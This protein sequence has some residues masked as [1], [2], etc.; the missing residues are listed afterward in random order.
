MALPTASDFSRM[1]QERENRFKTV[2]STALAARQVHDKCASAEP[3]NT[4]R[5]PGK[6]VAL[7]SVCAH[8]FGQ[9]RSFTID[10]TEPASKRAAQVP[11]QPLVRPQHTDVHVPPC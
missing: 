5:Q 4:P 6:L 3:G 11:V 7:R 2:M 10:V 9:T 1:S 8:C